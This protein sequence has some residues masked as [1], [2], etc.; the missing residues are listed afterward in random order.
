MPSSM[1][2]FGI[3]RLAGYWLGWVVCGPTW[4]TFL[5]RRR[6][7][8]GNLPFGQVHLR[9]VVLQDRFQLKAEILYGPSLAD[10]QFVIGHKRR[11]GEKQSGARDIKGNVTAR[12]LGLERGVGRTSWRGFLRPTGLGRR[13]RWRRELDWGG[14]HGQARNGRIVGG[15][16][17]LQ[18][19]A[20]GPKRSGWLPV[21]PELVT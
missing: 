9:R 1:T 15:Q 5:S 16:T 3:G 10:R 2:A 13:W 6:S 19:T 14:A 20:D 21:R 8:C 17:T 18:A 11:V 7:S 4:A 12:N